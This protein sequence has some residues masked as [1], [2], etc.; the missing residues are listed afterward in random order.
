[1]PDLDKIARKSHKIAILVGCVCFVL[2][3]VLGALEQLFK[4]SAANQ[5]AATSQPILG[6]L[7]VKY[8]TD[9]ETPWVDVIADRDTLEVWRAIFMTGHGPRKTEAEIARDY[10]KLVSMGE[11][12]S[13][14]PDTLVRILERQGESD[15]RVT[16]LSGKNI[17]KSGWVDCRW[18]TR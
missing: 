7:H 13:V 18:I 17:E 15:C 8:A 10:G 2:V 9:K 11:L 1:M 12:T 3:L 16:I 5:H 14:D 4:Q 6:R